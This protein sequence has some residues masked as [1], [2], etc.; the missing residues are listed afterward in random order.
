MPPPTSH[1]GHS[2]SQHPNWIP[3]LGSWEIGEGT[4]TFTGSGQESFAHGQAFPVGLAASSA[5]L[6][7]GSCRVRIKFTAPFGISAQA[8]GLIVG[9]RSPEQNYVFAQLGAAM[10]AYSLGEFVSGFGW[11]PLV[12]TGARENLRANHSYSLELRIQGQELR[13]FIDDVPVIQ[14]LLSQ[15]LEGK[16]VGLLAAGNS[17]ISFTDFEAKSNRPR[18]FVAMQFSEPF[19]TFYRE[20]ILPQAEGA[21][22]QVVRIDEKDGPGV[23]FQ[24]MQREIEQAGLVIAE[25]S[26]ANSNVFYEIGYAHALGKPTILLARRGSELPFDIRSYRVVFYNDTIGGKP[27]VERSLRKHLDAIRNQ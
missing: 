5:L 6:Q 9:Y 12:A 8:A 26:P 24:D 27:E 4:Q 2:D 11:R 25:I 3:I 7:N 18:A 17:T 23:I 1:N 21:G 19:D 20:V 10:S 13:V 15:P 14:H 22:F 16:Q